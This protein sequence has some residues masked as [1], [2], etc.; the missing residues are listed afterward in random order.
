MDRTTKPPYFVDVVS[1]KQPYPDTPP[2]P[3]IRVRGDGDERTLPS[4]LFPRVEGFQPPLGRYDY[5]NGQYSSDVYFL[6]SCDEYVGSMGWT[7]ARFDVGKSWFKIPIL[8]RGDAYGDGDQGYWKSIWEDK[9]YVFY[10][11][12]S[13]DLG[14]DCESDCY[15][16][17]AHTLWVNEWRR[18]VEVVQNVKPKLS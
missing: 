10:M 1:E 7:T 4:D 16:K 13:G 9:G 18:L 14:H 8:N 6:N 5:G 11:D 15:F 17:V 3:V 12:L 2:R